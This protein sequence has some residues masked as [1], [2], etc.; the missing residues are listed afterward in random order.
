MTTKLTLILSV[1]IALFLLLSLQ[2]SLSQT[3]TTPETKCEG[4]ISFILSP[5]DGFVGDTIT[6]SVGGLTGK[7]C[8]GK[9]VYI[10]ENSCQGLQYCSCLLDQMTYGEYGCVCTFRAP[11]TPYISGK[12]PS[13]QNR[14]TYYVCTDLD[15]DG[16]NDEALGEQS[17]M[18]LLVY[19][20][21]APLSMVT[22]SIFIIITL[23]VLLVI[24][25]VVFRMSLRRR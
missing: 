20:R 22:E 24:I 11:P 15:N 4:F 19:S 6:A 25:I 9:R 3:P 14:F 16:I 21:Y 23:G 13:R 5:S 1:S 17:H 10:K 7:G 8:I 12:E 2:K 18:D